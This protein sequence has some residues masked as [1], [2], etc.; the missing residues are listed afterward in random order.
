MSRNKEKDFDWYSKENVSDQEDFELSGESDDN[1]EQVSNDSSTEQSGS[2]SE[3]ISC[4]DTSE[5]FFIGKDK[6]TK[7][8]SSP[9]NKKVKTRKHNIVIRL[10]GVKTAA[11]NAQSILECWELFFTKNM[12]EKIVNFTNI[13]L[14]KLRRNYKNAKDVRPTS[15]IEIRAVLGLL[16]MIGV[17]KGNHVNLKEFWASDGTA[18]DFFRASMNLQRF[19]VLINALRFDNIHTR[20]E[21]TKLDKL[22]AIRE[23]FDMFND[24]CK[25]CY[26]P[27]QYLTIDEMLESFR[28]RC[29]FRQYMPKKPAKYG[30]KM[31]ALVDSRLFYTSN[32]E[33]YGGKQPNGPFNISNSV[34]QVVKRI[35]A[36]ILGTGRNITMDNYF[37]SIPLAVDLLDHHR[38]TVVTT[39]RKNK[40]E[41]PPQF[42]QTKGKAVNSSMFGFTEKCTLVSYVSKKKQKCADVVFPAQFW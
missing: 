12:I 34:D 9:E 4:N 35:S 22:A 10:P 40:R 38:T 18:P 28:G 3:D 26:T 36:P 5:K 25:E 33:I 14:D 19:Y 21:R 30:L 16:Y 23:I 27:G 8:F 1:I 39:L 15:E 2:E 42:L 29:S 32:I 37:A 24:K 7:W 31:W 13:Q 11:K 41:I 17:K 20:D 6:T